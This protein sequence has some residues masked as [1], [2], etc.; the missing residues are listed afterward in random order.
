MAEKKKM[1]LSWDDVKNQSKTLA[2]KIRQSGNVKGI[3]CIARGGLVPTAII[4]NALDIR[5]VKSI[6][7]VSYHGY[8]QRSAEILGSVE[9]ILDGEGWVFVDDLVDTGE[10]AKLIKKRYPKSKLAVPYTKPQGKSLCDF[11][12]AE[13]PQDEWIE[14]PWEV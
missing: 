13:V 14:F 10:T 5:N 6:A 11:Y 8:E 12:A 9:N 2:E 7:V 3:V 1:I 4:A